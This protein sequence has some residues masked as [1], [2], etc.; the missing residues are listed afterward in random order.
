VYVQDV[1]KTLE[2]FWSDR[3][4][5]LWQPYHTEVGAGTSNP[6][7]FLRVLGP[8]PWWV[9]YAEPSSRPADGRYGE[10]P[11]RLQHYFQFQ[12]ILKPSPPNVQELFLQSFEAI[13]LDL[14][15]HDFRFVEDNWQSPSLGAWGLG[16]EAWLDGM[17]VLQF[18]YFQECGGLKLPVRACELTYGVERI[19]MYLQGV[20]T[21]YDL[22]WGPGGVTYGH[23]FHA[24]E[25]EYCKYNFETSD[26]EKLLTIFDIWESEGK[27]LLEA[28]LVMPAYDHCLRLSH[29]FNLLDARGALSVTERARFLLRCR[30]IAEACARGYAEQREEMGYPMINAT[31]PALQEEPPAEFAPNDAFNDKDALLI[32]IGVEELPHADVEA[33]EQQA[34]AIIK[35]VMEEFGLAHDDVEIWVSPRRIAFSASG[36]PSRQPDSVSEKR[37]PKKKSAQDADG[38][39]TIPATKFAEAQGATADDIYFETQGKDEYAFVRVERKGEHL[40]DLMGGLLT[41]FISGFHF[42][43]T[44]GWED[45]TV[46]FSRPIRWLVALHGGNVVKGEYELRPDADG[47]PRRAIHTGRRTYGHRRIG[48]GAVDLGNVSDYVEALRGL[49]VLADRGERQQAL[50]DKVLALANAHGLVAEEDDDLFAEIADLLEWPEPILGTIP[51]DALTLPE[52]II[53]TPMKVHQRYIPMRNADGSLS[54]HFACVANGDHSAEGQDVIRGG[55]EKVLNARLRDAKFFW[56][57]DTTLSLETFAGRLDRLMFHQKLGSIADKVDR[58]VALFSVLGDQLPAVER[59]E[60]IAV[61]K[62]MKA[63]L[64]TQMVVEFDS[65]EGLVGKLYAER[66][67]IAQ[68]VAD[69]IFEHRLPRKAGDALPQSPLGF[70]AGILDRLDTLAGYFGIGTKVK[71]SSDPFGLRRNAL[72]LITLIREAELDVDLESCLRA[73]IVGYGDIT[74]DAETSLTRVLAFIT[75]RQS[76]MLRDEGY[77]HDRVDAVLAVHG[78]HPIRARKC[79]D[80]L[81]ALDEAQ[82]QDLAEQTKRMQKIVKEPSDAVDESLLS[83]N[84]RALYDLSGA[85]AKAVSDFAA[86]Q[87]FAEA[88][89]GTLVWIPVIADY[90]ENVMVNDKDDAVRANRHALVRDVFAA[91]TAAADFTRIEKRELKR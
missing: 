31:F 24:S 10:N 79:L 78:T 59:E 40:N 50:K 46:T 6:A 15:Q 36:V 73:A 5:L 18:T 81:A 7:T 68:P 49:Y 20:D 19:C 12:V 26:A 25:V 38:N 47:R 32:E 65:L 54:R 86:G 1:L 84:E 42:K 37:G 30:A 52:P 61:L 88:F 53:I 48:D 85:P 45:S 62:L 82:V 9:G 33:V 74:D 72:A 2:R 60:M 35:K 4:C 16:W 70:A 41:A 71:G 80:A 11:N 17:E 39:W 23:I 51:E 8:E 27:R 83:D 90:F 67:G 14:T 77:S 3:G 28:G 22:E 58:L 89:A 34:P 87:S 66:E 76:V 57:T 91:A 55:N 43:K 75:E 56:D 29:L 64:C 13:G 63:D 69:A 44:M 21:V